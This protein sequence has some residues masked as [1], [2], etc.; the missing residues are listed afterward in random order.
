MTEEEFDQEIIKHKGPKLPL[1]KEQPEKSAYTAED[2]E[3]DWED[4]D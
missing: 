1:D 3:D 4:E 2:T